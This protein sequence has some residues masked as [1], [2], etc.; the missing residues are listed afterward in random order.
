MS[1]ELKIIRVVVCVRG[2]TGSAWLRP[3][4]RDDEVALIR[5]ARPGKL[6]RKRSRSDGRLRLVGSAG[7]GGGLL[8]GGG[9]GKGWDA[10]TG[11]GCARVAECV[12]GATRKEGRCCC[13]F[14]RSCSAIRRLC[15][16]RRHRTVSTTSTQMMIMTGGTIAA[17]ST[18][19][20]GLFGSHKVKIYRSKGGCR[21]SR[22]G[23]C[24]RVPDVGVSADYQAR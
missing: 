5:A 3:L 13:A 2:S 21:H 23:R 18:T 6:L 20:D 19:P 8:A 16:R 22:R 1:S 7:G 17:T 4:P 10:G 24:I 14:A 12:G 9:G 15:A 11:C